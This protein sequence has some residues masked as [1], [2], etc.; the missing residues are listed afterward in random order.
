MNCTKAKEWLESN[1]TSSEMVPTDDIQRHLDGC[2]ECSAYYSEL[3]VLHQQLK[4]IEDIGLTAA[5]E[6]QL[7]SSSVAVAEN[8]APQSPTNAFDRW[9]KLVVRP[10]A[11]IAAVLVIALGAWQYQ[12]RIPG[13]APIIGE[14]ESSTI[15]SEEALQIYLNS[16]LDDLSSMFD[17]SSLSYLTD[18][19][20]DRQ[21][22]D[23]LQDISEEELEWLLENMKLEI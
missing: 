22:A 5:E 18:E 6:Q 2:S 13:L 3:Q 8:Y 21:A 17:E 11:A 16:E 14:M 20:P 7:L 23:M 15:S 12:S 4:G 1:F 10:V 19:I 9:F